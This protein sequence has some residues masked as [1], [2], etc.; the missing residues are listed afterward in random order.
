[1]GIGQL[2]AWRNAKQHLVKVCFKVT[3]GICRGDAK[4]KPVLQATSLS[5]S[6]LSLYCP[7]CVHTV[8]HGVEPVWSH[9]E[10]FGASWSREKN[11]WVSVK[12]FWLPAFFWPLHL[13]YLKDCVLSLHC[14]PGWGAGWADR[15][16][17]QGAGHGAG[18][19]SECQS[20]LEWT[21]HLR[22]DFWNFKR[23]T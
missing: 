11:W 1:M 15:G 14:N 19:R 21:R 13:R 9:I 20:A 8:L 4:S 16:A 2:T 10:L 12:Y 23:W 18:Q 7:H 22:W 3:R 6:T 5:L 17:D